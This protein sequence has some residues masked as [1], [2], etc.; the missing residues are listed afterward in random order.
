VSKLYGWLIS[1][2]SEPGDA[3]LA[4]LAESFAKEYD[5]AK[6]A[7]TMLRSNLFFSDAAYRQR[8]K[9]PLEYA[10]GIAA[11]FEAPVAPAA[12]HWQL[13]ALGQKLLEPPTREGWSGGRRWLNRFTLVG[14]ANLAATLLAAAD[15]QAIARKHG[16]GEPAQ[17]ASFFSQLLVQAEAAQ[18]GPARQLAYAIATSPEFQCS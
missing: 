4:P 12:L 8:V 9:S 6:L 15:P 3:L 18:S 2:T 1:E 5:I 16:R 10:L 11:A 13:A 17:L 14:R 7:G